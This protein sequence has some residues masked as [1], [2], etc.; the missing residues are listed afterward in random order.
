MASRRDATLNL[1]ALLRHAP[2]SV[3]EVSSD[4]ELDPEPELL[5][6][7]GLRLDGPLRWSLTITNTGGD[8]DFIVEGEVAGTALME[9][10][11][12]LTD[13]SADVDSDFVYPMVY[14]P[15]ESKPL[16]MVEDDEQD[17][18][19]VFTE[20]TID[21][22]A[23]LTQVFAIDVPLTALCKETCRGL[24]IDGVNLNEHPDHQ[25][26]HAHVGPPSPFDA[27][28]DLEDIDP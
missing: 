17:E 12:C 24:S 15:G 1:S 8:D 4:G 10:R 16:E 28:K 20:P 6:A 22:A 7:D 23:F 25:A 13:V 14:R 27:L 19:L 21:F 2:G 18:L 11:R 5:E 26:S 3:D 9:C